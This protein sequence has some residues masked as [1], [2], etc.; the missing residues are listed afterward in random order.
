MRYRTVAIQWALGA[1]VIA[2][3]HLLSLHEAPDGA[4]AMADDGR[5]RVPVLVELFTSEGCS[6]CPPAEEELETLVDEQPVAWARVVP[7]A[8]HVDYWNDL[9]WPD[10]FSSPAWT[11]R[12]RRYDRSTGRIYT[13]QAV[14]QGEHECVGSDRRALRSAVETAGSRPVASMRVTATPLSTTDTV[15]H[16]S[17]ALSAVPASARAP[18]DVTLVLVE[19]GVVVDVLYGENGGKRLHHAPLARDLVDGGTVGLEGGAVEGD[20][21]IPRGSHREKLSVV[22]FATEATGRVVGVAS[23]Q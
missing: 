13:P 12:Q 5:P 19:R 1:V 8:F 7:I 6:S 9:G 11:D 16:A 14:V 20:L 15:W 21:R 3:A 2:G 10:A 23:S 22:A 17:V 18:I 4:V